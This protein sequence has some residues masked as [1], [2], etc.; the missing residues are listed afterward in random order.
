MRYVALGP[1]MLVLAAA[2]CVRPR[3]EPVHHYLV[4][5]ACRVPK[6]ES[7]GLTV[8]VYPIEAAQPYKLPM[9]YRDGGLEL[10]YYPHAQWAELPR[11]AVTEGLIDALNAT[12]RFGDVA[13]AH[14]VQFPDLVLTGRIR[15]FEE[16]R[17][18]E[19][20]AAVCEIRVELRRSKQRELVWAATLNSRQPLETDTASG[21][22]KAMSRAVS[23]VVEQAAKQIASVEFSE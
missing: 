16:D 13:Y 17:T 6:T 19:P 15:R 8:G 5:L 11:D 14:A 21:L 4:D 1:I 7:C 9:V 3:Y 10:H 22:A 18:E 12:G 23:A 20:P 2:G